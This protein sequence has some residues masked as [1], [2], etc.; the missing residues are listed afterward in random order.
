MHL[1]LKCQ[2]MSVEFRRQKLL[3]ECA[4]R[5]SQVLGKEWGDEAKYKVAQVRAKRDFKKHRSK[6]PKDS[7]FDSK[8][9]LRSVSTLN[10]V[11]NYERLIDEEVQQWLNF[12]AVCANM[13]V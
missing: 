4:Q 12:I 10:A 9:V 13:C 1:A 8:H 7:E 2:A 11:E 3:E 6:K 5:Y